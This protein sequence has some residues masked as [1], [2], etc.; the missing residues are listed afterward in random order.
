M[1]ADQATRWLDAEEQAAWRSY[2][3]AVR[4]LDE[5]LRR[6]LEEHGLSHPEYEILVR[7][8]ERDGHVMR[9]S[10]LAAGVVS[11]RSRLTHTVARLERAG[12]VQRRACT[13]DGRGVECLLTTKGFE[14]LAAAAHTHVSQV[15]TH[16]LDAMTREQFL[17]M[18][19]ALGQV[20]KRLDPHGVAV[21]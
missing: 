10:E 15:R 13:R 3:R 5:E 6:G 7:L 19:V 16:L 8:S 9:M 4:L 18:G 11:S 1:S 17:A 12:L 21:V 2:L 14:V 20:S